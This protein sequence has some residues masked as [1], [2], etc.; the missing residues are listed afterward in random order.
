MKTPINRGWRYRRIEYNP[1]E[2]AFADEWEKT[3]EPKHGIDYGYGTL[4]DLFFTGTPFCVFGDRPRC[5]KVISLRE[6]MIV[7]TVIQW[8]GSNIGWCWLTTTLRACGYRLERITSPAGSDRRSQLRE[9]LRAWDGFISRCPMP[10]IVLPLKT[11]IDLLRS[12]LACRDDIAERSQNAR[13][14]QQ[15]QAR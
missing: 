7:A 5:T 15:E 14:D 6:R 8:L 10:D 4:Q 3:N 2:K 11:R 1:R 12:E 9:T 13:L